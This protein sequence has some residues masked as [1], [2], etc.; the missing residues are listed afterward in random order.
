MVRVLKYAKYTA[1]PGA[2]LITDICNQWQK[3]FLCQN[4]PNWPVQHVRS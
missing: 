2:R 4:K 1:L 3:T